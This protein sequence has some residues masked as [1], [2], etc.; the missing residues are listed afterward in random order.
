MEGNLGIRKYMDLVVVNLQ[1]IQIFRG[2]GEHIND[3]I[4]QL[5]CMS[6]SWIAFN[7]P[8]MTAISQSIPKC[9]TF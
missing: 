3:L 6:Y 8:P 5:D 1:W 7:V 9:K 2:R 4:Q